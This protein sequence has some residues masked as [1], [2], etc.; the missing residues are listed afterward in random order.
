[1]RPDHEDT[2]N[3]RKPKPYLEPYRALDARK[4][5][6]RTAE[7]ICFSAG[8]TRYSGMPVHEAAQLGLP[9]RGVICAHSGVKCCTGRFRPGVDPGYGDF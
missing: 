1:M 8:K 4:L 3:N 6:R 7:I 5:R 9:A 2:T